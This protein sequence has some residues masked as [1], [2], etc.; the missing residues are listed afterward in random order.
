MIRAPAAPR[1]ALFGARFDARFLWQLYPALVPF[2][3]LGLRRLRSRGD[4]LR[5]AG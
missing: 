5:P 3:L 1:Y 4:P 2:A